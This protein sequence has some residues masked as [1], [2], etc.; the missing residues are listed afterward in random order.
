MLDATTQRRR[1]KALIITALA[2]AGATALIGT[3][4]ARSTAIVTAVSVS[5][6]PVYEDLPSIRVKFRTAQAAPPGKRYFA[7]LQLDGTKS[8]S[9]C[10]P[11]SNIDVVGVRGGANRTV[12]IK[13]RPEPMFG[14]SFC[15][16]PARIDIFMQRAG[17]D[18]R[19]RGSRA[20]YRRMATYRLRIY[21][22]P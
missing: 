11:A 15:P 14:A 4:Q 3:S 12:A 19:I 5:P 9:D 21:R 13:L 10:S 17:A 16:G 2:L 6:S 18:G 20:T 7:W 22:A 1:T 8:P